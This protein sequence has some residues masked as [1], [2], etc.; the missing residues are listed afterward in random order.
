MLHTMHKYS[1][2]VILHCSDGSPPIVLPLPDTTFIAV[3]AYQN[4]ELTQLK[5]DNNPF[6]KGFRYK[7]KGLVLT[8]SADASEAKTTPINTP[9]NTP[10]V[11]SR[12]ASGL[13][14]DRSMLA[15]IQ[16]LQ[17]LQSLAATPSEKKII[18]HTKRGPFKLIS[19]QLSPNLF[20]MLDST[21]GTLIF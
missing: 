14:P 1:M 11:T 5:I 21:G 19:Q 20:V 2:E 9:A 18:L 16:H 15:Y 4:V 12:P 8:G 3:S 17:Q 13:I 7:N 10:K 6:A